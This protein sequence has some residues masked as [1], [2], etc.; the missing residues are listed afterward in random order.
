MLLHHPTVALANPRTRQPAQR[1]DGGFGAAGL[2]RSD[3]PQVLELAAVSFAG[4]GWTITSIC[5]DAPPAERQTRYEA[6]FRQEAQRIGE[7]RFAFPSHAPARVT[8]SS[9]QE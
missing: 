3:N 5:E 2:L 7:I 6:R 9:R 1:V 8:A 4:A